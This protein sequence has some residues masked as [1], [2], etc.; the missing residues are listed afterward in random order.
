MSKKLS[1]E[2]R[3][4]WQ[5]ELQHVKKSKKPRTIIPKTPPVKAKAFKPASTAEPLRDAPHMPERE[6]SRLEHGNTA[7][8][9]A[10]TIRRMKR[11]QMPIGARIDLHGMTQ[12]EAY[13]ALVACIEAA[14]ERNKKLVLV[15]TG[16]GS[17]SQGGGV[18]K[19]MLPVWLNMQPL[20]PYILAFEQAQIAHGGSGAFYVLLKRNKI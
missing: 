4:A 6:Y 19:T 20:R 16:K 11:G 9:D 13:P 15:I 5:A 8:V 14:Y 17:V 3:A 18:L 1:D 2:D 7:G 12:A 10:G